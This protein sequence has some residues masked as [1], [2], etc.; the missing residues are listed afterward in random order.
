MVREATSALLHLLRSFAKLW[1]RHA[2]SRVPSTPFLSAATN[3]FLAKSQSSTTFQSLTVSAFFGSFL[4]CHNNYLHN[5]SNKAKGEEGKLCDRCLLHHKP[6]YRKSVAS[7][8]V[9]GS[10]VLQSTHS[11]L[12]IR[13]FITT[14]TTIERAE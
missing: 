7:Q 6:T 10:L 8:L 11:I 2:A 1:R 3:L 5:Y 4:V 13:S 14:W 9:H 12:N